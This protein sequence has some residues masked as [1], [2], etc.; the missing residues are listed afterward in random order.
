M[1]LRLPRFMGM[2]DLLEGQRAR[3]VRTERA[4]RERAID[5]ATF[6]V[7]MLAHCGKRG[8]VIGDN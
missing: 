3:R 5:R 7:Q 1:L 2:L 4:L 8:H 6:F